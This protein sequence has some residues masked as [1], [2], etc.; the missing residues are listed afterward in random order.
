MNRLFLLLAFALVLP[1]AACADPEPDG[2]E[3]VTDDGVMIDD[4]ADD[5][6]MDDDMMMDDDAMMADPVTAQ[7]TLDAVPA[8]GLTAMS[9]ATAIA[10]IDNWI[11]QLDGADFEN[12]DEIRDGLMTL[13][14][15]LQTTPLDG[16]A[17]GETLT[18]LG[19]WTV[20]SAGAD[21]ALTN[22]GQALESAGQSL[23]SM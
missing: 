8:E 12:A 20:Q 4:A 17:I 11:A 9:P 5:L 15:Q 14:D 19:T 16:S 23:T 13:K 21:A 18:N 6:D 1:L 7:G 22:L 10:N 2:D 3:I